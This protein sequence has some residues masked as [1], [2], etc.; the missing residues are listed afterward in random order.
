VDASKS[1]NYA[2]IIAGTGGL[3]KSGSG[4][5]SLSGGNT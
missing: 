4:T 3:T 1:L 5:L 2:G